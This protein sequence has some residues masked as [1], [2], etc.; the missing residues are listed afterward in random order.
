MISSLIHHLSLSTNSLSGLILHHSQSI[1]RTSPNHRSLKYLVLCKKIKV[2]FVDLKW[3]ENIGYLRLSVY[4]QTSNLCKTANILFMIILQI[5]N[6]QGREQKW[7]VHKIQIC[8]KACQD[9]GSLENKR[10]WRCSKQI[11]SHY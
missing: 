7:C 2:C 4:N 8:R 6:D 10:N 11:C 5:G 9:G 3:L 1:L